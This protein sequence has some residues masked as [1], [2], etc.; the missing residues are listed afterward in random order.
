MR[1]LR[2]WR[3]ACPTPSQK[4]VHD[5]I[6]ALVLRTK[7]DSPLLIVG[8]IVGMVWTSAG[9]VGVLDRCLRRML[10]IKGPNPVVGQLRNLGVALAVAVLVVMMVLLATA[11]TGSW[12]TFT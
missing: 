9:A 3:R 4:D 10:S 1:R 6:V 7:K 12:I 8:A 2:R 11:A 5:Q